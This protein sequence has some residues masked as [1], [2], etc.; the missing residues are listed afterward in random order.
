MRKDDERLDPTRMTEKE[1]LQ[2]TMA[3]AV[4]TSAV[5]KTLQ[6]RLPPPDRL[7]DEGAVLILNKKDAEAAYLALDNAQHLIEQMLAAAPD[8]A[9][10][11]LLEY[12]IARIKGG[13]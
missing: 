4:A 10:V 8:E 12:T 7:P 3:S 11:A 5:L 9:K 1:K 13:G 6:D 2:V